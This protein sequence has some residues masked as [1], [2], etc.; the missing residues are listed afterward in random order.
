MPRTRTWILG[1]LLGVSLLGALLAVAASERGAPY[2]PRPIRPEDDEPIAPARTGRPP[3]APPGSRQ[4]PARAPAQPTT[5]RKSPARSVAPAPSQTVIGSGVIQAGGIGAGDSVR[6]AAAQRSATPEP[7]TGSTVDLPPAPTFPG[8]APPVKGGEQPAMT[9]PGL[10]PTAPTEKQPPAT[11]KTQTQAPAPLPVIPD[12]AAAPGSAP[13]PAPAPPGLPAEKA[14]LSAT[15]TKGDAPRGPAPPPVV[16]VPVDVEPL[17]PTRTP[18]PPTPSGPPRKVAPKQP[19][20]HGPKPFVLVQPERTVPEPGPSPIHRVQRQVDP[21]PAP[22]SALHPQSKTPAPPARRGERPNLYHVQTPLV[23]LEKY[24]P[25]S[26][27]VG[28]MAV[29]E[30]VV[31]NLGPGSAQRVRITEELPPGAKVLAADPQGVMDERCV[32]WEVT[33]PP[34]GGERVL[35]LALQP[36][37]A[38][39]A[40]RGTHL[41]VLA[42]PDVDPNVRQVSTAPAPAPAPA[43][44]ATRR[45]TLAVHVHGPDT[46]VA[47]RQVVFDVTYVNQGR[48]PI[49]GLVLFGYLPQGLK[50]PMGHNIEAAVGTL[51]AGASKTI[52]LTV[53]A[54][55]AGRYPVAVKVMAPQQEPATAE[56][57]ITV[58]EGGLKVQPAPVS[59]LPLGRAGEV[60]VL[61]S[62]ET[63]EPLKNV[64]VTHA[65][66]EG[67]QFL[68]ASDRGLCN[69]DGHSVHWL[70]E[71]LGPGESHTLKLRIRPTK[72]GSI[73]AAV[74]AR[75]DGLD[76][77]RIERA[78][79]VR[80]Q[81]DLTVRVLDRD[82]PLEVGRETVYEIQVANRGSSPASGVKLEVA[83]TEGLQ[84]KRASGPTQQ[85]LDRRR[86]AF[87][88]L[89]VLQPRGQVVYRV[90]ALG[91]GTAG[92]RNSYERLCVTLTSD[93]L[94]TPVRRE[95]ETLVYRD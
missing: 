78:L 81:A 31:R 41:S 91:L 16:P 36:A 23:A 72:S 58:T 5:P 89:P 51:P 53:T 63:A 19:E 12:L 33:V 62:N 70:L 60:H 80:G 44:A 40:P 75:A 8:A 43:R 82:N 11:P 66:E 24:G 20:S 52:K 76:E 7:P 55:R 69:A 4:L 90:A 35:R 65:L 18:A 85:K 56:T 47:G 27:K 77:V 15:P 73:A 9:L 61:V 87:E 39:A 64:V 3:V 93:Q 68:G 59:Q 88:P 10:P 45:P 29:Y 30:I 95:H 26:L 49:A 2:P 42:V 48:Q 37:A 6:P 13:A 83:F 25:A 21:P 92:Q 54:V 71:T 67:M 46:V 86:V 94:G 17:P 22:R 50:H 28:E 84:A 34:P 57:T 38:G 1:L 79:E 74:A 32:I 14:P